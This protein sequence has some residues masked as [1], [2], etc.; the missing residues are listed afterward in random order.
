MRAKWKKKRGKLKRN[1]MR[2]QCLSPLFPS[3]QITL[4]NRISNRQME[5]IQHMCR[6]KFCYMR[7]GSTK[8]VTI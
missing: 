6:F 2:R 8:E 7:E 5:Q 4:P 3:L 1:V